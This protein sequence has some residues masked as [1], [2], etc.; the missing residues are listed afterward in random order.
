MNRS[1][2]IVC[3]A[4]D[5]LDKDLVRRWSAAGVLPTFRSLFQRSIWGVTSTPPGLYVGAV[6]PSFY[7]GASPA[8]HGRYCYRQ[9]RPG[10]YRIERAGASHVAVEP[11]WV[12]LSKAGRRVAVIDVPKT[13]VTPLNGI[14]V[15]DWATHDAEPSGLQTWPAPFGRELIDRFGP[16]LLR[17]CDGHN[18]SVE[19]CLALRDTL[20]AQVARKTE[21]SRWM[22]KQARWELLLTVFSEAHCAGH[23]FWHLHDPGCSR[24]DPAI[25]DRMGN[26]LRDIY[27]A[28]DAAVGRVLESI[29][30]D[31]VVFVVSSHGMSR[32]GDA[33]GLLDDVLLRL[34]GRS[35]RP[36]P[37][38]LATQV[39]PLWQ[40]TPGFVRAALR[41]LRDR[42]INR[43]VADAD[44][45][46]S[47]RK[48]FAIPNNDIYGGIRLNV[49]GREPRGRIRPGVE[50]DTCC[51]RVID[52][53]HRITDVDTGVLAV[54]AVL[55]SADF[56]HGPR[57][58]DFPD[59]LVEWNR[60]QPL[61]ALTSDRI[62]TLRS[63]HLPGRTG[64][65]LPHGCFFAYGPGCGAGEMASTV[66]VMDFAPTF[67]SLLDVNLSAIDGESF[68]SRLMRSRADRG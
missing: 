18:Q 50:Y 49:I 14:Q 60:D 58:G 28:L 9:L 27:I 1:A 24:Y 68:A 23:Q 15:V 45:I 34:E 19:Q 29:D 42:V 44:R 41:P 3:I 21:L 53:L 35:R 48:C 57:V 26:P 43:L 54:R 61:R 65:H 40:R 6:W 59:L 30:S 62:G 17:T 46:D 67:A 51:Q 8:R 52:E 33:S 37:D 47:T 22:L 31:T 5:A 20:L 64:D 12:A 11:F 39:L 55:R 16:P 63:E 2:Q 7:T 56:Y 36:K 13:T 4:L 25:A 66:S 38:R 10:T 32:H